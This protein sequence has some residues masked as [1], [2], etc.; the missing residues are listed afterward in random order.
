MTASMNQVEDHDTAASQLPLPFSIAIS[1]Q[2]G[3]GGSRLAAELGA[4]LNWAV[5]DRELIT[6]IVADTGVSKELVANVDE[7]H[8]S[9]I[10]EC[11]EA[12]T[13]APTI[14]EAKYVHRLIQVVVSLAAQ[15]NCIFV[16]RGAGFLL[17]PA[18]RLH[19]RLIAPLRDRIVEVAKAQHLSE[20][21]ATRYIQQ[22]DAE[23][24][25]FVKEHFHQDPQQEEAYDLVLNT[26]R[27]GSHAS[28]LLIVQAL[29]CV[30]SRVG[31]A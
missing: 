21:A 18:T 16:G 24:Q 3:A 9:W 26:M 31:A 5:Y 14:S 10:L 6:R 1:R 12:F 11:T 29:E 19:V 15:G 25:A 7:R 13:G 27:L 28:A 8:A 17:P 23:R 2:R 4:L 22:V 20:H 30:Q